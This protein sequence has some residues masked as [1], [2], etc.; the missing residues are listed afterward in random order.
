MVVIEKVNKRLGNKLRRLRENNGKT[1]KSLSELFGISVSAI[2]MY[3][4]GYRVPSDD[5]K[6]KYAAYFNVPVGDIFFA[7]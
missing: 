4:T 3:E 5:I 6:K 1:Q 7:D 2:S